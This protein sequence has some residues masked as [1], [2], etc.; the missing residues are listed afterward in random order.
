[1]LQALHYIHGLGLIHCDLKPE[2]ILMRS[3]S[4]CLV[5]VI[6]FGS[7]CYTT[8]HLSSYIQSRSY[9]APEV[10]LGLPYGRKIDLWSLGCIIAELWTGQ[11]LFQNDS[12]QTLLA[13]VQGVCPAPGIPDYMLAQG[14]DASR[15]FTPGRTLFEARANDEDPAMRSCGTGQAPGGDGGGGGGGGG[16]GG[17]GGGGGGGGGSGGGGGDGDG[18]GLDADGEDTTFFLLFPKRTSLRHRLRVGCDEFIDFM[19][20]R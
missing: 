2:N 19:E 6:D 16:A 4:R 17:D 5:K 10:I 12:I 18:A 15:F 7:S 8:D 14:R 1:M 11:V 20:G 3:Y 9:R 13:R